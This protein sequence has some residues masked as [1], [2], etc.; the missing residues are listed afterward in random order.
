MQLSTSANGDW[1]NKGVFYVKRYSLHAAIR[2]HLN[3]E[4]HKRSI[5]NQLNFKSKDKIVLVPNNIEKSILQ[6]KCTENACLIAQ[7]MAEYSLPYR[8]Y[9]DLMFAIDNVMESIYTDYT[10]PM[11]NLNHSHSAVK[12]LQI[13]CYDALTENMLKNHNLNNTTTKQ[14]KRFMISADKGKTEND[15]ERQVNV[16]T[17]VDERGYPHEEV[18]SAAAIFDKNANGA[19]QHFKKRSGKNYKHG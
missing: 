15:L 9:P 13:A 6:E 5:T 10:H 1:I 7:L 8:F 14:P 4:E 3:S 19:A 18:L 2:R 12:H 16:A 11:G 17:S